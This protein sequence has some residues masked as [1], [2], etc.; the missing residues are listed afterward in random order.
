MTDNITKL[1]SKLS[2]KD[3]KR[4]QKTIA[5]ITALQL[6]GLDIKTLKGQSELFRARVGNFRII[7]SVEQNKTTRIISI[8]RS[9]EDTYK[10]L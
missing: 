9:K 2:K 5:Q 1:L 6:E 8:G 3:L 4:I 10:S 7:F